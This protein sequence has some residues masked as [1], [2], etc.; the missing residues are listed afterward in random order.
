MFRLDGRLALV[1]GGSRGIGRAICL[2]LA[3]QGAAVGI[4]YRQEEQKAR[5]VQKLIA[6]KGGRAEVLQGDVSK[7]ADAEAVVKQFVNAFGGIDILVNNA[8]IREDDLFPRMNEQRF[9]HVMQV[10]MYSVFYVTKAAVPHFIKRKWGRII[11]LSSLAPFVGSPGQSNYSASKMAVVGFSH[12]LARELAPKNITVNV[13]SPGIIETDF[14]KELMERFVDIVK[15]S[16]PMGRFGKPDEVTGAV[17]YLASEEASFV[18]G[19][20]IHVNG[21]GYMT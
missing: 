11:N 13:I 3:E 14:T 15:A 18:T 20:T 2:A 5:E 4:N 19:A 8:G 21:G 6:G 9:D 12:S 17:V 1:T 7:K 10:N 16:I